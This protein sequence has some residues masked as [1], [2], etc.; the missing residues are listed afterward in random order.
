MSLSA[1]DWQTATI[2]RGRRELR[3]RVGEVSRGWM[4]TLWLLVLTMTYLLLQETLNQR[5]LTSPEHTQVLTGLKGFH[6]NGNTE[7][8]GKGCADDY[9]PALSAEPAS[10]GGDEEGGEGQQEGD[11]DEDCVDDAS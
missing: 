4:P 6:P 3:C 9:E 10:I 11:E 8:K 5:R 7:T 2:R 1:Y